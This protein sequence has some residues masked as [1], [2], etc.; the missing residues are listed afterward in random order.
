VATYGWNGRNVVQTNS[1][2]DGRCRG[3]SMSSACAV[4]PFFF[5]SSFRAISTRGGG[6][7][8]GDIEFIKGQA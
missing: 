8:W 5:F 2:V 3:M 7:I 4:K 1:I 6:M